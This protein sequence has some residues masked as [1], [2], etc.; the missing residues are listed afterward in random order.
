MHII[1]TAKN[2][3]QSEMLNVFIEKKFIGLKKYIN[4]LKI[5]N[6]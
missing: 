5:Q 4:V 1:I 3:E 2:L 6:E